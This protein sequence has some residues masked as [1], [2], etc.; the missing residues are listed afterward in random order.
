MDIEQQLRVAFKSITGP[1]SDATSPA[2]YEEFLEYFH[3]KT[4]NTDRLR[5]LDDAVAAAQLGPAAYIVGTHFASCNRP[6]EAEEWLRIAAER[7]VGDAAFRLAQL[8]ESVAVDLF[9]ENIFELT[10]SEHA[11]IDEKYS[12]AHYW[13][14]RAA[15]VG[16]AVEDYATTDRL[17]LPLL[18]LDCCSTTRAVEAEEQAKRYL[19]EAK[20]QRDQIL[21]AVRADANGLVNQA[22]KEFNELAAHHQVLYGEVLE[23]EATIARLARRPILALPQVIMLVIRS[24]FSRHL[25]CELD[26]VRAA[27]GMMAVCLGEESCPGVDAGR[28]RK[29]FEIANILLKLKWRR[30]SGPSNPPEEEMPKVANGDSKNAATIEPED[31]TAVAG[32]AKRRMRRM[33]AR[34]LIKS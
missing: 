32:K 29:R 27:Y 31:T 16:Y 28:H 2:E 19:A 23:L 24:W 3:S 12:E 30:W 26:K 15:A 33:S 34:Q 5:A 17:E 14:R 11:V 4:T 10:D 8:Y 6:L 18:S 21:R 1:G 25:H 20:E 9:N 22:R 13:Y 7:D